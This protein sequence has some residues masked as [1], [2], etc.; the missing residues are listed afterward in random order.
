MLQVY[1]NTNLGYKN[2]TFFRLLGVSNKDTI[3]I[4]SKA[5]KE[6]ARKHH[7]DKNVDKD[8]TKVMQELTLAF[9]TT[10]KVHSTNTSRSRKASFTS[11]YQYNR[12]SDEE[13]DEDDEYYDSDDF[14]V[15]CSAMSKKF[16]F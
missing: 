11:Y 4:I 2:Q 5:Y 12:D 8:T 13:D 3:S 15:Y 16:I 1:I 14:Y 7:P 9:Q 6:L 10:E